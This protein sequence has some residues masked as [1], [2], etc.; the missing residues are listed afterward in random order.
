MILNFCSLCTNWQVWL[1]L[2][3]IDSAEND[4]FASK[5]FLK[6]TDQPVNK[7]ISFASSRTW[8]GPNRQFSDIDIGHKAS[9]CR[10]RIFRSLS[11]IRCVRKWKNMKVRFSNNLLLHVTHFRRGLIGL[12]LALFHHCPTLSHHN[13]KNQTASYITTVAFKGVTYHGETA[14][15]ASEVFDLRLG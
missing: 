4:P 9:K 13:N 7:Q 1:F 6:S 2:Q 14:G 3:P 11:E 5:Q 12:S 10:S 8:G 15:P